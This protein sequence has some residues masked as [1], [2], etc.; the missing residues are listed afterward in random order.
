MFT[1]TILFAMTAAAVSCTVVVVRQGMRWGSGS[2]ERATPMPGDDWFKGGPP[3]RL[4][5]TRAISIA[6]P[7]DRVWPWLAQL[8]RGA[9][10][11]SIDALDNG[12][13]VSARR[14]VSWIPAPCVGDAAAI[15]YLRHLA[16]GREM[17]WWMPGV[18]FLGALA[19]MAFS[20]RLLPEST[21]S[22]LVIR[23]SG[24]AAGP[25]GW[26]A[27]CLFA[28]I[29][30]IMACRQLVGIKER[31]ERCGPAGSWPEAPEIGARDQYQLY[32]TI[33]ASGERAGRRGREL[34]ARW[35]QAA[36]KAGAIEDP[37]R[38]D[39]R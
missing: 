23:I 35:R 21:G 1:G 39:A 2:E 30:S 29:D 3:A 22:R 11:Y 25:T 8:G 24:D 34:A 27:L 18:A 32:E 12:G 16:P 26:S 36:I 20:I 14:L 17:A 28:A 4:R 19:R 33:Y 9:G 13:K 38:E 6:E 37:S 15:G 10:W 7:P 31:V 5:M